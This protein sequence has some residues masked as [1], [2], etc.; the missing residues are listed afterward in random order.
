MT[1]HRLNR[2]LIL[3]GPF[4]TPAGRVRKYTKDH[5]WIDLKA[6]GKSGTL[7][8]SEYAADQLGDVVYVELPKEGSEF[9]LGDPIGA[10]E[11]VKSAADIN[12]PVSCTVKSVNILLEEKPGTINKVPEDDSTGG[13]WIAKVT[14]DQEGVDQMQD[15]MDQGQYNAFIHVDGED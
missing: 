15:L 7:G 10:V 14:L 5:E 9:K 3:F 1:L 4:S 6:D 13:G 11:S 8:I 12:A 2:T